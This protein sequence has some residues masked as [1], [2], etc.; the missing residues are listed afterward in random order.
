MQLLGKKKKSSQM[1]IPHQQGNKKLVEKYAL[2]SE[3][4]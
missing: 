3:R 2:H 1:I 4:K